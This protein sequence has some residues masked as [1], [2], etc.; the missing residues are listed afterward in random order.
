MIA[1]IL[2]CS[3][4]WH[5]IAESSYHKEAMHREYLASFSGLFCNWNLVERRLK[6]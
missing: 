2:E 1:A 4:V 5:N 6:E 3:D